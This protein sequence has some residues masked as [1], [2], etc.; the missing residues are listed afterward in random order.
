MENK[1]TEI[2]AKFSSELQ[3][4]DLPR[5]VIHEGKR[6]LLDSIGLAIG[7][8]FH[9]KGRLG[10]QY[11]RM[12]SKNQP[13]ATIL[14]TGE[15]VSAPMAAYANG[16][17]MNS[18][19]WDILIPPAHI[20]PFV[21]PA[22]LA[23]AEMK[24]VSG[25]DLITALVLAHDISGRIAISLGGHRTASREALRSFSLGCNTFGATAGVANILKLD[26]KKTADALGIAGYFTPIGHHQKFLFT[27]Y[28]GTMKYGSAGWMAQGGV[29]AALLA[30]MGGAGDH[31]VLDG[32]YGYWAMNGSPKCDFDA[33]VKGLGR[34]WIISLAK[35]KRFPGDGLFQS[36]MNVLLEIME[37]NNLRAEEMEEVMVR[38]EYST[39]L[40]Q[41]MKKEI[42]T[43]VDAAFSFFHCLAVA[44]HGIKPGPAWY[45]RST[46]ENPSIRAFYDKVKFEPY[47]RC[48]EARIQELEVEGKT[49]INRR[50]SQVDV[51]ARG[52]VFSKSTE[53]CR[54]LS[55]ET[56]GYRATDD[57]LI[58]KFTANTENVLTPEQLKIAV[59]TIMNLE[60]VSNTNELFKTVVR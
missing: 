8:I 25:K 16:E 15:K 32:E 33:M 2:L 11:A 17:L 43:S 5:D 29:T 30:E 4:N 23:M 59:D 31:T 18:M 39:D 35:Y 1:V 14:G 54:W 12:I 24:K 58:G 6:V 28:T 40:P 48:E 36:P 13:D 44:A 21:V 56:P 57:D 52:K 26:A 60:K 46:I 42:R 37:E 20:A 55:G 38:A 22:V 45:A 10:V 7:S 41:F 34:D 50:P 3:Y 19:D 49:Y 51:A 53:Y 47:A 27:P 9:D